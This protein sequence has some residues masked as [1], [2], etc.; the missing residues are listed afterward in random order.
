M[1]QPQT[2][3][4]AYK[5]V[6][7]EMKNT[8]YSKI[9][10]ALK[11]LGSGTYEEIGNHI[12]MERHQIGR[13][14]KE[15]ELEELIYKS[16]SKRPTKSGRSAYVYFLVGSNQPKTEKEI[17]FAKVKTTASEHATNIIKLTQQELF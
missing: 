15:M 17:N 16:G 14:L 8:H 2:S 11:S 9:L 13:R 6:T 4:E 1:K 5:S 3:L 12:G 7:V 10:K